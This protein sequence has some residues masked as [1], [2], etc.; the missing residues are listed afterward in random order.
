[1]VIVHTDNVLPIGEKKGNT[2]AVC[3]I[4]VSCFTVTVQIPVKCFAF[5]CFAA[6]YLTKNNVCL[7]CHPVF[8][9]KMSTG[10]TTDPAEVNTSLVRWL[11]AE[12]WA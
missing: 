12:R 10:Q 2:T 9:H 3:K 4:L 6:I 1:M 5:I 8:K 11:F 7:S